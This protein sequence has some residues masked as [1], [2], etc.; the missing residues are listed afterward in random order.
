MGVTDGIIRGE[1]DVIEM[2]EVQVGKHGVDGLKGPWIGFSRRH[3][4][5]L[6]SLWVANQKC[7]ASMYLYCCTGERWRD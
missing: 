6:R 4:D 1:V 7:C 2:V 3:A 5:D